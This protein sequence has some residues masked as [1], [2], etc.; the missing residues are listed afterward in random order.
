MVEVQGNPCTF[1]SCVDKRIECCTTLIGIVEALD[2]CNI[3]RILF[4][5]N[6]VKV[7]ASA[8]RFLV[9]RDEYSPYYVVCE[10]DGC[11]TL[12]DRRDAELRPVCKY[13]T[14][15][16]PHALFS[17]LEERDRLNKAVYSRLESSIMLARRDEA[18]KRLTEK[19]NS[20]AQPN[21]T[22]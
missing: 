15:V 3:V 13:D 5:P 8:L 1:W 16:H 21:E 19:Q 22:L 20:S 6:S 17:V 14:A 12:Y 4:G 10:H 9:S 11:A 18:F 2:D 7:D